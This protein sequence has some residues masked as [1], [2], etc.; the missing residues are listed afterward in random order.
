MLKNCRRKST[1]NRKLGSI[2]PPHP[3]AY[4]QVLRIALIWSRSRAALSKSRRSAQASISC[5]SSSRRR[6][7]SP[8]D[9]FAIFSNLLSFF[10]SGCCTGRDTDFGVILCVL[11]NSVCAA[12]RARPRRG[13]CCRRAGT[14]RANRHRSC[15]SSH[16][17]LYFPYLNAYRAMLGLLSSGIRQESPPPVFPI[18]PFS[19]EYDKNVLAFFAK[20]S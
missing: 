1:Y 7:T 3:R 14:F 10:T 16:K 9:F 4:P 13:W 18:I 2:P 15:H 17:Q 8:F 5:C 12:R 6:A 11:L 19:E 20:I